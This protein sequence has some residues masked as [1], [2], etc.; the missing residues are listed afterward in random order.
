MNYTDMGDKIFV[1]NGCSQEMQHDVC[2]DHEDIYCMTEGCRYK[3]K[4]H[5]VWMSK[6]LARDCRENIVNRR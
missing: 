2:H 6:Q 3:N 5:T 1:C 4:S